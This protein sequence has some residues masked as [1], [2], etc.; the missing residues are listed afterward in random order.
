MSERAG[1][2][3]KRLEICRN[4]LT[5][6]SAQQTVLREVRALTRDVLHEVQLQRNLV[7]IA[8]RS[9]REGSIEL[10]KLRRLIELIAGVPLDPSVESV[11]RANGSD[12]STWDDELRD[13]IAT[14]SDA[15]AAR[16][17]FWLRF[18]LHLVISKKFFNKLV[19]M[20]DDVRR[21][22]LE[23]LVKDRLEAETPT[24]VRDMWQRVSLEFVGPAAFDRASSQVP[25]GFFDAVNETTLPSK[26]AAYVATVRPALVRQRILAGGDQ[27]P[28]VAPH[29]VPLVAGAADAEPLSA[30]DTDLLN[31]AFAALDFWR[32]LYHA[33]PDELAE[34]MSVAPDHTLFAGSRAV[35]ERNAGVREN[36]P[37]PLLALVTELAFLMQRLP[38]PV[39]GPRAGGASGSVSSAIANL[40]SRIEQTGRT[41]M[42][43]PVDFAVLAALPEESDAFEAYLG[44]PVTRIE[45]DGST[46]YT[47]YT[48]NVPTT[49][50][51][52]DIYSVV[53]GFSHHQGPEEAGLLV[54][55]LFRGWAPRFVVLCGIAGGISSEA[56]LGDVVVARAVSDSTWAKATDTRR[57]VR[58]RQIQTDRALYGAAMN[59]KSNAWRDALTVNPPVAAPS[60]RRFGVVVSG[61]DL[62]VSKSTVALYKKEISDPVAVEMESGAIALACHTE[63]TKPGFIVIKGV[64]DYCDQPLDNSATKRNWREFA[65]HVSATFCVHLLRE[66]PV[67]AT[68]GP[69]A[70]AGA[71]A[72][73]KEPPDLSGVLEELQ[74]TVPVIRNAALEKVLDYATVAH[75]LPDAYKELVVRIATT[76]GYLPT[77]RSRAITTLRQVGV[78]ADVVRALVEEWVTGTDSGIGTVVQGVVSDEPAALDTLCDVLDTPQPVHDSVARDALMLMRYHLKQ[79]ASRVGGARATRCLAVARRFAAVEQCKEPFEEIRAMVEPVKIETTAAT[80]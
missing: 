42:Q 72:V 8:E 58:W 6:P 50:A 9:A 12:P 15:P 23:Q 69:F 24:S 25:S 59:H 73:H 40:T 47:L 71:P 3:E 36:E 34:A 78:H 51:G 30:A 18:A 22:G 41:V 2:L 38:Q 29:I 75:E 26:V 66:G 60:K 7:R 76:R 44:V 68:V 77:E 1:E 63:M 65:A 37:S 54:S 14:I 55:G 19:A 45:N 5:P 28:D 39:A 32:K 64:S 67:P 4:A 11:F 17:V 35:F 52:G 21:A 13:G 62:V 53:F 49:R 43:R 74:G 61:G 27:W 16:D 79:N 31:N 48:A 33:E 10:S 70:E 20:N 80:S 46:S 56:E 57:V